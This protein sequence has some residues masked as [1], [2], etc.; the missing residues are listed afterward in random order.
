M[1]LPLDTTL[2]SRNPLFAG[3]YQDLVARNLDPD[4]AT[5]PRGHAGGGETSGDGRSG[6]AKHVKE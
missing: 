6:G 4:G 3:M 2:R 1:I 5:K